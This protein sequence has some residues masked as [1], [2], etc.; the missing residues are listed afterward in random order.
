MESPWRF[1]EQ[2]FGIQ[3]SIS[4]FDFFGQ[5]SQKGLWYSEFP[6]SV[7]RIAM[8]IPWAE[9]RNRHLHRQKFR[10]LV[11]LKAKQNETSFLPSNFYKIVAFSHEMIHV[12]VKNKCDAWL[13]QKKKDL[14]WHAL[15]NFV[16][17]RK[18]FSCHLHVTFFP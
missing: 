8:E 13:S 15:N 2:K 1:H 16:C 7:L 9:V 5:I 10:P 14:K 4:L 11:S 6:T 12:C 3:N 18:Q 17:K